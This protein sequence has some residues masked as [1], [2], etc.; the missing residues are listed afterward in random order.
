MSWYLGED[1]RPDPSQRVSLIVSRY[2]KFNR[3][4]RIRRMELVRGNDDHILD[5][6][7]SRQILVNGMS[8][9]VSV[10]LIRHEDYKEYPYMQEGSIDPTQCEFLD[11][12]YHEDY[13]TVT[14]DYGDYV[15]IRWGRIRE[16]LKGESV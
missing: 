6:C 14:S 7:I 5:N 12:R 15:T 1:I 8:L 10:A 13:V 9:V 11:Y 16:K 2:Y 4:Q 3:S